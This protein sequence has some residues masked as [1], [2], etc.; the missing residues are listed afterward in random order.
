ME[1][2]EE[3]KIHFNLCLIYLIRVLNKRPKIIGCI[4]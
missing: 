3:I 2:D 4:T 1:K